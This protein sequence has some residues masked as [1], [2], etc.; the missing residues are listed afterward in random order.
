MLLGK[1]TWMPRISLRSSTIS[2]VV[3]EFDL[4]ASG[5]YARMLERQWEDQ[6]AE[7]G[8]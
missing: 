4:F 3:M 2:N 1:L 6:M 8:E 5:E 7:E